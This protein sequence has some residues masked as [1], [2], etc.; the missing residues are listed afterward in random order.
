MPLTII[1]LTDSPCN[2]L[3]R[4]REA[5]TLRLDGRG[6]VA[7]TSCRALGRRTAA[8]RQSFCFI[9]KFGGRRQ[10]SQGWYARARKSKRKKGGEVVLYDTS[11][12]YEAKSLGIEASGES[13][14]DSGEFKFPSLDDDARTRR[15]YREG[16]RHVLQMALQL[17]LINKD[18][19]KND[20]FDPTPL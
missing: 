6:M 1:L 12:P 20:V 2:V 8:R 13:R 10:P 11:A 9:R 3:M 19:E 18:R 15:S 5:N 4:Y 16:Q 7:R 17:G 14:L